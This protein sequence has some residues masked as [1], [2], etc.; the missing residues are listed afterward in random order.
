MIV[1]VSWMPSVVTV[2]VMAREVCEVHAK[3]WN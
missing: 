2:F 1:G 3:A